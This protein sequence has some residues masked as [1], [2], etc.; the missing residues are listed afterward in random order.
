[1]SPRG[2][3]LNEFMRSEAMTRITQ[4]AL[5]V[6][7]NYG[8]YGATMEQ[9]R[10]A[11]GLSKGLVYHYFP[12]K[13]KLFFHL[14]DS[15]LEISRKIWMEALE[16]PGTAWEK[17]ERLSEHLVRTTFTEESSLYFLI[18][19]QAMT[20]GKSI[21]GLLEHFTQQT[22]HYGELPRLIIEAQMSGD[23]AQG[24]PAV[25]AT[26]YFS[27]FWGFTLVLTG[28][29]ELKQK[30]TPAIFTQVLRSPGKLQ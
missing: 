24:D 14:V 3:K 4:A 8:Y 1:M 13:E 23:A 29:E 26:T 15:A 22:A 18:M 7:S 21:P 11:S 9:I 28:N 12:S 19:V 27:L 17:I 16:A 30:I 25:L 6:F 5:Q 2:K 20:Q 10:Q